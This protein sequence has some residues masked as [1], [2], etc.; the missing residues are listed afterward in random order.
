MPMDITK[1]SL[2]NC[3]VTRKKKMGMYQDI[4]V[5]F[6]C[7]GVPEDGLCKWR[8]EADLSAFFCH[9]AEEIMRSGEKGRKEDEKERYHRR[10][11][12]AC[13]ISQ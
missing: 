6:F 4:S 10:C 2:E 1:S 9:S 12:G 8:M 13:G 7:A 11:C 5:F 3:C